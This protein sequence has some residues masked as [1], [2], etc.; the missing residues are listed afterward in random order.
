MKEGRPVGIGTR[1][2]QSCL[3]VSF[4]DHNPLVLRCDGAHHSGFY[5]TS[6]Q[7]L[8][9][10]LITIGPDSYDHRAGT[11]TIQRVN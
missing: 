8:H 10:L 7:A 4:P 5:P 9:Y 11:H 2:M 6:L 1:M 3:L